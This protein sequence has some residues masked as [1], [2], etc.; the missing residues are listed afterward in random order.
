MSKRGILVDATKCIGCG[1]CVS[2]C[3]RANGQANHAATRLDARSYTF[4]LERG[5][6]LYVR[7][8]CM[9]CEQPACASACP[10]KALQKTPAGPVI[11]DASRC[12]G[13]RYCQVACPF[14]VPAYEWRATK[15]RVQKCQMCDHRG[16]KG[17]GKNKGPACAEVCPAEA[18]VAGER[19]ALVEEAKKRL[20][21]EPE[22]YFSYIYGLTEVGGTSV[23]TIGPKAPA[24]LG[25]PTH[26]KLHAMPDLTW[27]ALEHVPHVVLFGSALLSGIYWLTKRRE[28]VRR[29]E[30]ALEESDGE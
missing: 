16:A 20:A 5:K 1:E 6:E 23:I 27:N 8:L 22:K 12:L 29:M 9:H 11:Y 3:Q 24:E 4:L 10:V 2:A 19:A 15:P 30:G 25:L 21:Q 17:A 18:T 13:C 28:E 7:R 26:L 14:Q